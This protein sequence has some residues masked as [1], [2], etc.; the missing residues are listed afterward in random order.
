MTA[1]IVFAM[2]FLL[3]NLLGACCGIV[4]AGACMQDAKW[5]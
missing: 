3:L 4:V 2:V 5:L 1:I